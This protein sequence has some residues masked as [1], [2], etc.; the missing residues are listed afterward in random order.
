MSSHCLNQWWPVSLMHISITKVQWVH[1]S[2]AKKLLS[3]IDTPRSHYNKIKYDMILW[4]WQWYIIQILNPKKH[5]RPGLSGRSMRCNLLVTKNVGYA[6][7]GLHCIE[8]GPLVSKVH[9]FVCLPE[10]NLANW[11]IGTDPSEDSS[12]RLLSSNICPISVF[13]SAHKFWHEFMYWYWI[14]WSC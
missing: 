10:P 7:L 3:W 9:I 5:P 1:W 2:L 4:W 13:M 6:L 8:S 12:S 14:F 11:Y